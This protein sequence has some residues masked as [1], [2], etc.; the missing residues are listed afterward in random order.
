MQ[1]VI[2]MATVAI[3]T[4]KASYTSQSAIASINHYGLTVNTVTNYVTNLIRQ[5]TYQNRQP[6]HDKINT[7][8][9]FEPLQQLILH[10]SQLVITCLPI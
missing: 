6:I 7:A 1:T 9:E 5:S 3:S 4:G 10:T 2:S 8:L